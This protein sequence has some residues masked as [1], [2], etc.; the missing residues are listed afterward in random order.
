M[1]EGVKM[2]GLISDLELLERALLRYK[3]QDKLAR[4][5]RV[6]A[7]AVSGYLK[8]VQQGG[9]LPAWHRR[10]LLADQDLPLDS[11]VVA[12]Q[13]RSSRV[14][15]E[16]LEI[17]LSQLRGRKVTQIDDVEW[18]KLRSQMARIRIK[19]DNGK[20]DDLRIWSIFTAI[21][22]EESI[23]WEVLRA[24][25]DAAEPWTDQDW[26]A[27][28]HQRGENVGERISLSHRPPNE[29]SL[30]VHGPQENPSKTRVSE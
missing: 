5:L 11:E 30:P 24:A 12:S 7:G 13:M 23:T 29:V 17:L 26:I 20:P 19:M 25:V 3:T 9:K 4:F 1:K 16:D 21:I 6:S 14:K 15:D 22:K 2:K 27:L 28:F 18:S 10:V 8:R